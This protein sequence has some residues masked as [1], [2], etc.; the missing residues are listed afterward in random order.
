ML[1]L[2]LRRG[3]GLGLRWGD[4]DWENKNATISRAVQRMRGEKNAASGRREGS[5]VSKGPQDRFVARPTVAVPAS[6]MEGLAEWRKRAA[7]P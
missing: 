3:E 5:L 2:G 1:A 7:R 4:I 6:V